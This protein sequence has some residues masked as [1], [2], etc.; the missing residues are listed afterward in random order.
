[1]SFTDDIID[2]LKKL[3]FNEY[4]AKIYTALVGL[5]V[6]TA[7]EI[8]QS[9]GVPPN[10]VYSVIDSLKKRGLVLAQESDTSTN[11]YRPRSPDSVIKELRN[12]YEAAFQKTENKLFAL[13]ERSKKSFIP[14]MWILRGSQAVFSKIKEMVM[15]AN[16]D[17]SIGI[18]SHFDLHL[19]GID[20]VLKEA[21]GHLKSIK[22][23]TG[24]DGIDNPGEVNVL[25]TLAEFSQVKI[26]ENFHAIWVIIDSC[27]LL[28]GSY[29]QLEG[30]IDLGVMATWTD[31]Q[32]FSQ[33]WQRFVDSLWEGAL[34]LDK[35]K[36][37]KQL[38]K[39]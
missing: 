3:G 36:N 30:G 31:N 17:V 10:K 26:S 22:I 37:K 25:N 28:Q 2:E 16:Q 7:S 20:Q 15:D 19:H 34:P 6:A 18:D 33:L 11:R 39:N 38:K 4:Q 32:G 27:E 14:E 8:S 29:A 12:E 23:I 21:S 35:V 24:Q 5:G 9:S 13:Y 1:M